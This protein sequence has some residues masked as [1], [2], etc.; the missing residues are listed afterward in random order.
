MTLISATKK[1]GD[2]MTF[3]DRPLYVDPRHSIARDQL[4]LR[5]KSARDHSRS[6]AMR[7]PRLLQFRWVVTSPS[8]GCVNRAAALTWIGENPDAMDGRHRCLTVW[9]S[10]QN[11]EFRRGQAAFRLA[12][13][14]DDAQAGRHTYVSARKA[15]P[16][17]FPVAADLK[18]ALDNARA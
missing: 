13:T 3:G 9:R 8:S 15:S 16:R 11:S 5:P 1:Q 12:R 7:S 14:V 4:L 6:A 18:I 17:W 10:R 2:A